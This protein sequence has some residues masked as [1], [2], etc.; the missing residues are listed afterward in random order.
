MEAVQLWSDSVH[1]LLVK[2][3]KAELWKSPWLNTR[4]ANGQMMFD[5]NPIYSAIC[6]SEARAI[7]VIQEELD[8]AGDEAPLTAWSE[9]TEWV[10]NKGNVVFMLTIV[11]VL[12]SRTFSEALEIIE[13]WVTF[14]GP[15]Q[16]FDSTASP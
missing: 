6:D 9:G 11:C 13:R 8:A 7:R 10:T 5:G 2:N 12:S 3:D 4:F 1:H 15:L 16:S 14:Q